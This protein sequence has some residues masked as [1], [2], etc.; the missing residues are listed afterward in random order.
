MQKIGFFVKKKCDI[1]QTVKYIDKHGHGFGDYLVQNHDRKQK[2]KSGITFKNWK[3][4]YEKRIFTKSVETMSNT[5]N[6]E[7][8]KLWYVFFNCCLQSSEMQIW[9]S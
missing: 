3:Q 5:W 6:L 4:K 2:L 7:Q 1:S 9:I 8:K